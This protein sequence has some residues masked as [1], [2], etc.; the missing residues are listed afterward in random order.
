MNASSEII[1]T[2][3]AA[4]DQMIRDAL[5]P[6][7]VTLTIPESESESAFRDVLASD[8]LGA[9]KRGESANS[10]NTVADMK[11]SRHPQVYKDPN[12]DKPNTLRIK[13]NGATVRFTIKPDN[14][15]PVGI[16]FQLRSG[17]SGAGALKRLGMLNFEQA[18]MP[19]TEHELC[20]TDKFK[21]EDGDD[22]YKFSVIIQRASDGAIGIIDPGIEHDS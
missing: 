20:V 10:R 15:L 7:E 5:K 16:A 22:D 19:R 9:A 6:A 14:Y 1:T 18:Q 4:I 12:P 8:T 21:D 17:V 11:V 3:Q 2:T 13:R